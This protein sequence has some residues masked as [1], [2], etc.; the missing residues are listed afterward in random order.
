[1]SQFSATFAGEMSWKGL[2]IGLDC[3]ETVSSAPSAGGCK[4]PA[5]M[6]ACWILSCCTLLSTLPTV[7]RTAS[8][9][10]SGDKWQLGRV[11]FGLP[12]REL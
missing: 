10:R 8:P 2:H 5:E 6:S 11:L 9:P 7:L 4:I 12:A 1:M 3:V